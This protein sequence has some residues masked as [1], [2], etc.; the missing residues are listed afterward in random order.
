MI[1]SGVSLYNGA[2][3]VTDPLDTF[4]NVTFCGIAIDITQVTNA[5]RVIFI[6]CSFVQCTIDPPQ[7]AAF[8]LGLTNSCSWNGIPT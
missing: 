4:M 3:T 2:I 7:V 6:G 8:G 5:E 1:I